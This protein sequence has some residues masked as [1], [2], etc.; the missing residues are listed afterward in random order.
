MKIILIGSNGRMG[1]TMQE[2]LREKNIEFVAIDKNN[3]QELKNKT[4]DII[5]DFSTSEALAQNL[6]VAASKN[7]PIVVATTNHS[8]QNFNL[9]K[10]YKKRLAIFY[11]PNMSIQFNLIAEFIKKLKVLND[12]DFVITETHH[13]QKKDKPS[14]SA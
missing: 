13:K 10:V 11:S 1:K 2:Y 7:I 5:V 4:A 3:R 12:C 9:F 8:L 6:E 14:G